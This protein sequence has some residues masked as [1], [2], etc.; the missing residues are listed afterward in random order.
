MGYLILLLVFEVI[1]FCVAFAL[2]GKDIMA[3]SVMMCIMFF[4]STIFLF[5][6]IKKWN[7][8]FSFDA[9]ML[10]S[11]G[12]FVF[13][14]AETMFRCMFCGQ[15]R[16]NVKITEYSDVTGYA[17]AT[18]KLILLLLFNIVVCFLYL[19]MIMSTVG[20]SMANLSAYFI[21][22]RR[23]GIDSLSSEGTSG[24]RGILHPLLWV[25]TA[26]GYISIY[27]FVNNWIAKYRILHKQILLICILMLS[28]FSTIM[29]GGRTGL[30][31]LASAFLITYYIIW[32]QRNG[33]TR[34][35]SWK[36]I[37]IG[38]LGITVGIPVFYYSLGMLGRT[39]NETIGDYASHYLGSSIDLFNQYVSNPVKRNSWGEESLFSVKKILSALGLGKASTSYNLEFR[40]CGQLL[41]NVYTFFRRPLHDFGVLGMYVFVMI[42]AF[43]FAWIYYKKIKYRE[44]Q[45][46]VPWVLFYGYIYYWMVCSSIVQ[47]SSNYISAGTAITVII[48]ILGFKFMTTDK[49]KLILSKK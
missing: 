3:P 27:I 32:H 18:W 6:N 14:F 16:G 7:V 8:S 15:L 29:S 43:L 48:I 47:Y 45:K 11:S 1:W 19:R 26:S 31:R 49:F 23:I 30:L 12:I 38:I 24:V 20:G 37:R 34:N 10:L 46:T 5:L 40:Y 25:V 33:W 36:F 35:L 28:A 4:I 9:S 13:I 44:K 17:V 42:I 21:A 41:S 39:S 2:S 22:Y